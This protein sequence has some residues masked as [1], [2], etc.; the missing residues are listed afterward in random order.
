M[1]R[2]ESYRLKT[3]AGVPYLLPFGQ[4]QADRKRGVQLNAASAFLWEIL[5]EERTEEE[6]LSA[7]IQRYAPSQEELPLFKKDILQCLNEMSGRGILMDRWALP[8]S[9]GKPAR[10]YSIAGLTMRLYGSPEVIPPQLDAFQSECEGD[11]CQTVLLR[12]GAPLVRQNGNLLIR[13]QDLI[14]IDTPDHYVIAFPSMPELSELHLSK[15]GKEAILYYLLPVTPMHPTSVF[16]ALRLMF[17]YLA[18]QLGRIAL[19]SA[20]ILY[21]G[22]AWLFS[23]PSGMGKSTHAALWQDCFHVKQINGDLNLLAMD[24]GQPIVYGMPWCGT[25]GICDTKTYSLGGIIFLKQAKEN[26]IEELSPDKKMLFLQQRLIS[27]TWTGEM[28]EA[29]LKS[30]MCLLPHI[31]VCRLHCAKEPA[32]ATMAKSWIDSACARTW[33]GLKNP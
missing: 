26:W 23:G 27:P 1:K 33:P 14:V 4:M 16:H 3:L 8:A 13:N 19:H 11:I 12:P 5:G 15:D 17:L 24:D 20:S 2:N 9:I 31:L 28:V 21:Q 18:A 10:L 25:S 29:N 30:A 32:A 22:K 7:C 6:I